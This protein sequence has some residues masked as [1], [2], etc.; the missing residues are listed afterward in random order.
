MSKVSGSK[1]EQLSKGGPKK[2]MKEKLGRVSQLSV[3]K[4]TKKARECFPDASCYTCKETKPVHLF[5][6]SMRTHCRNI[7]RCIE[8]QF[9]LCPQCG[10]R[11]EKSVKAGTTPIC[12]EAICKRCKT[13]KGIDSFSRETKQHSRS[14]WICCECQFPICKICKR[15]ATRKVQGEYTDFQWICPNCKNV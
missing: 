3:G 8:C 14:R 9:P 2:E 10:R 7:W 4:S 5:T 13:M 6:P 12:C 15:Q 11:P 1:S